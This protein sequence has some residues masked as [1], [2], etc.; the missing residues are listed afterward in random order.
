MEGRQKTHRAA[1]RAWGALSS[2][3]PTPQQRSR[4]RET[5]GARN[6]TAQ[7][8]VSQQQHVSFLACCWDE[9]IQRRLEDHLGVA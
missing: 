2:G 5:D 4:G 3:A 7:A 1:A 6:K 9:L 8:P